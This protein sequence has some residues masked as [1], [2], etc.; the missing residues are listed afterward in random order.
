MLSK[1][2]FFQHDRKN[3]RQ[4]DKYDRLQRN[5]RNFILSQKIKFSRYIGNRI[6][7]AEYQRR[8]IKEHLRSQRGDH[9]RYTD[10]RHEDSVQ[11]SAEHSCRQAHQNCQCDRHARGQ[12]QSGYHCAQ[13]HGRPGRE[14]ISAGD[15]HY[16]QS[17]RHY[18]HLRHLLKDRKD[19]SY[20][21]KIS[22][23]YGSNHNNPQKGCQQN[24]SIQ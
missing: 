23:R 9:R 12:A 16:C 14:I 1:H 20:S 11:A 10:H 2:P 17:N 5:P 22:A 24:D 8:S 18:A 21:Q 3:N 19:I 6:S 4:Q 13:S 7:F 15:D